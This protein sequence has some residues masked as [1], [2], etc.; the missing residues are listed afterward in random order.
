MKLSKDKAI[1]YT[2]AIAD[3]VCWRN[4]FQA[5]GGNMEPINIEALIELQSQLKK[6]AYGDD[7]DNS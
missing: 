5:A 3:V 7:D 1:L 2:D 4:G 6:I